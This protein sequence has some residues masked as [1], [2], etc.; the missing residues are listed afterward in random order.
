MKYAFQVYDFN[1]DDLI[2][3]EDVRKVV[4]GLCGDEKQWEGDTL[5]NILD[6]F[7]KEAD[8]DDDFELD[9]PEFENMIAKAPDFVNSFRFRPIS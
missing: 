9:F 5:E 3:R 2:C 7:F 1:D 6:N 4:Q 8:M